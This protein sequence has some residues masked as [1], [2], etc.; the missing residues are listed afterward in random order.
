[1]KVEKK[2]TKRLSTVFLAIA[3]LSL[4]LILSKE[5]RVL[6]F[7]LAFIGLNVVVTAYKRYFAAPIEIEVLSLGIVLCSVA[8][9]LPAGL[10]VAIIGGIVYTVLSTNFSPFTIPMMLG[11]IMMAILSFFLAHVFPGINISFLGIIVNLLHNLFVFFIYDGI[12]GYDVWKNAV[13]SI[14]NFTFNA[15][16]FLNLAPFLFSIMK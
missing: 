8:F 7:I 4:L 6:V 10:F 12:F 15:I 13:F 3:I 1:M 5:V 14:S 9:G 2:H 16:I 11:Y